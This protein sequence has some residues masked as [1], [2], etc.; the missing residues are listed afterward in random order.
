MS[1]EIAEGDRG[2]TNERG[3]GEAANE[4]G[5]REAVNDLG[6][7]E[8]VDAVAIEKPRLRKP[9]VCCGR[10]RSPWR[11]GGYRVALGRRR[12]QLRACGKRSGSIRARMMPM[13]RVMAAAIKKTREGSGWPRRSMAYCASGWRATPTKESKLATAMVRPFASGRGRCWMSAFTGTTKNPPAT[14]RRASCARTTE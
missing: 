10:V 6:D 1:G 9:S 8:T 7:R 4:L 11:T 13:S 14:P 2:A 5:D 12:V 3:D